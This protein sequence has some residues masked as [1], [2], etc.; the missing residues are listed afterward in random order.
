MKVTRYPCLLTVND[1]KRHEHVIEQGR[2]IRFMVQFETFVEGKWLPV[3]RYDTAHGLP[4]VDRTLPDGT[5]EKIP[6]LTKDL[7]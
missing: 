7:G 2:V 6:L 1:R 3:I 4:H 5:I